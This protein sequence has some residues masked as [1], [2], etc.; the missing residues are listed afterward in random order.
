MPI[1][2]SAITSFIVLTLLGCSIA[3][4]RSIWRARPCV[5]L[6]DLIVYYALIMAMGLAWTE[7]ELHHR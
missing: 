6:S 5:A 3:C 1:S 4:F 7:S 2:S